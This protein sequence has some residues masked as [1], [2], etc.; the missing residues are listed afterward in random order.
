MENAEDDD[1][2]AV[3]DVGTVDNDIRQAGDDELA[4]SVS[5]PG[6]SKPRQPGE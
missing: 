4:C 5:A 3:A 2:V 1:L 6:T